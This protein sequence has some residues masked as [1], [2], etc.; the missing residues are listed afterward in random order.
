MIYNPYAQTLTEDLIEHE[1]VHMR[2]QGN[3]PA[4]WWKR[5]LD[6]NEF[7]LSQELEAYQ[8]QYAWIKEHFNRETRRRFLKTIAKDL[9]SVIY[10]HIITQEKAE[11][12][13][14]QL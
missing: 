7:R 14:R 2:Q 11:E 13:I 5:Y 1:K 10:G 8:V 4:L 3:D 9:S 6:D 12:R